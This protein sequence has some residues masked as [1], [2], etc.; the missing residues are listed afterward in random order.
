M[1]PV[2]IDRAQPS[3]SQLGFFLLRTYLQFGICAALDD[4]LCEVPAWDRV[5]RAAGQWV[6]G[7]ALAVQVS[8]LVPVVMTGVASTPAMVW[9]CS[10][11]AVGVITGWLI[12]ASTSLTQTKTL[13]LRP[14]SEGGPMTVRGNVWLTS[15]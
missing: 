5:R 2:I 10:H 9:F 7:S 1:S 4:A 8:F 11:A 3:S 15:T 14:R 6:T 12:Q 13:V